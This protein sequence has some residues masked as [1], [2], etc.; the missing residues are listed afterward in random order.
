MVARAFALLD[1][2]ARDTAPAKIGCQRKPDRAGAD[3][4]DRCL[5]SPRRHAAW[6]L[7][8][9][10]AGVLGVRTIMHR[11]AQTRGA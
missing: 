1:H 2:K 8:R 4:Q 7:L 9:D 10:A 5:E 11:R 6:L 3:Y